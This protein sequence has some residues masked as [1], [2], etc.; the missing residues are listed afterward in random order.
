MINPDFQNTYYISEYFQ[1]IQGE[2]NY[3]GANSFFIR[4]QHCNLRCTWCDT[5]YTWN[6]HSGAHQLF[7]D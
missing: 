1:S 4:F 5:K 7:T 3:T 6:K 2:G